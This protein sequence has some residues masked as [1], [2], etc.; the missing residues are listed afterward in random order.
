MTIRVVIF[1]AL[2]WTGIAALLL[3]QSLSVPAA[4]ATREHHRP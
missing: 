2:L 4:P 1:A 3:T